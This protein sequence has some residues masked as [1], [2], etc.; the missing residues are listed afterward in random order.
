VKGDS[1]RVRG[2]SGRVVQRGE[3]GRRRV[4]G[5]YKVGLMYRKVNFWKDEEIGARE[6]YREK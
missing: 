5:M 4:R 6:T 2:D 3:R 1:G